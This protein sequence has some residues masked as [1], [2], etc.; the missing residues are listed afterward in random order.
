MNVKYQYQYV[1]SLLQRYGVKGLVYKTLERSQSP[2][3]SYKDC[4]TRYLPT[5]E[6]LERQKNTPLSFEPL[7]S[8]VVP[9]YETPENYLKELLCSV[10]EQSYANW[11]LCLADGSKSDSVEKIVREYEKEDKRIRYQRLEKNG[12]IS[13]NTNGGFETARGEYIALMDH[14]DVLTPN[15]VYEMVRC[16]NDSYSEEER[17]FAMIYSDE[18]K[19]NHDGTAF[20]R[21]HFKPDYNPE[22]LRRN[23]YFC[24]FLM[25]SKELLRRTKGLRKEYDGA[26]DYDFVLRCVEEGAVI[27]HVPKILYHWRIHEGS[28]AGNSTDKAYA[29][30]NGCRAIEGHLERIGEYGKAV[31]TSNLGVYRV[32]YQL[33]GNYSVTVLAEDKREL[34]RIRKHYGEKRKRNGYAITISYKLSDGNYAKEKE[35][36]T[37]DY[38]VVID[39]KTHIKTPDFIEEMLA[40]CQHKQIGAV[41]AKLV[42][43]KGKVA[44]CGL[45]YGK[46]GR[47]VSAFGG[48]NEQY[49][50]YFLRAV[51][52]QNVSACAIGCVMFRGDV[53]NTKC[54]FKKNLKGIYRDADL[55]MRLSA[56]FG[57]Q[58]VMTP[59]VVAVAT[60]FET[61]KKKENVIGVDTKLL[62][63]YDSCYNPNLSLENGRTYAMR[64]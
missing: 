44:S 12:G 2:M 50:G 22:F 57:L 25:F 34:E 24:H 62:S 11:E 41:G 36:I 8:I 53:W 27:R 58:I 45:I 63:E 7:V 31:V 40:F 21:P 9:T 59:D 33:K 29:F 15:A 39:K 61:A 18:D 32:R 46:D 54:H 14:D 28:T 13:E 20:S 17:T 47:L 10:K 16:L 5:K 1:K 38:V 6:E 60:D 26:Q 52:P 55:C 23:N 19:M 48:L 4:Y 37:D 42:T 43:P 49:K 64:E 51:V 3:L 56:S 35:R 30:D